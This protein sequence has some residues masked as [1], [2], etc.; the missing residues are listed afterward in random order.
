MSTT[1][2][3]GSSGYEGNTN[4]VLQ[5]AVDTVAATGD[6][7]VEIPAGVYMMHDALHLRSGVRVI[8]EQGTILRKVPSVASAIRD[9]LGYGFYEF[10]VAEPEKFEVGMGVQLYDDDAVGFYTTVATIIGRDGDVFYTNRMFHHDYR[11]PANGEVAS[12]FS[13][14]EGY[15]IE[16]AAAMNLTLDG[17]PEETRVLTGCRGGGVFLLQTHR[18]QLKN[19]EVTNYRGDAIS[20]QQS[21]D[22]TVRSCHLHHNTGGGLHPGSGTVRYV[23]EENEVH[24]NGGC[25]IFYC[26]RTTHSLCRNNRLHHNA[27]AGIS[28]GERDTDHLII[29]NTIVD[30]GGPGVEFRQPV[31]RG[32]DRVR[33]ERNTIGPNCRGAGQHEITIEE[34][35]HDIYIAGNSI[36]HQTHGDG[37]ALSVGAGC[38]GI[39]FAN[40]TICG[41][42]QSP[43]DID[44]C[45]ELV[46]L[47]LPGTFPEVGPE[48]AT[49]QSVAH[50]NLQGLRPLS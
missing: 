20:F 42:P 38:T 26:L 17:N 37:K 47:E 49:S 44:G 31:M 11:P 23:M 32:G 1:I 22:I 35:L 39:T 30:N 10:T 36:T 19:V 45:S 7:A 46:S 50:L 29:D 48:A 24:D 25:G 9:Y 4:A 41:Q 33:L 5:R 6:G 21:T 40:N 12:L 27:Q 13:L 15:Q 16:D 2:T 28:I 43:R 3:I 8:G 34:N 14:I 18:I